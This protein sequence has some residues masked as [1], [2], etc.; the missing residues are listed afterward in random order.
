M[1]KHY[2]QTCSL[3]SDTLQILNL[4][5]IVCPISHIRKTVMP[6]WNLIST[7]KKQKQYRNYLFF[8]T[9]GNASDSVAIELHFVFVVETMSAQEAALD[10]NAL[11]R[12]K[13]FFH[14]GVVCPPI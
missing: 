3:S 7:P 8:L 13:M 10:S 1:Y 4:V 11:N 6:L 2:N 14:T 12:R 5:L 9:K